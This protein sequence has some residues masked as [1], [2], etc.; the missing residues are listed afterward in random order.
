MHGS[1]ECAVQRRR[2][3]MNALRANEAAASAPTKKNKPPWRFNHPK[4]S[5]NAL[6]CR[7]TC[8]LLTLRPFEDRAICATM[9]SP[10]KGTIAATQNRHFQNRRCTHHYHRR[11]IATTSPLATAF[12]LEYLFRKSIWKKMTVLEGLVPL[13]NHSDRPLPLWHL[14]LQ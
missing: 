12:F 1:C 10:V 5:L 4:T 13:I 8:V 6:R 14:R 2:S 3:G 7:K 11:S 9:Y